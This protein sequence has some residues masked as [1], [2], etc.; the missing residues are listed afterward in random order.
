[1]KRNET[2]RITDE[3]IAR[4]R[5]VDLVSF[6]NRYEPAGELKRIG[7][8]WTLKSHDSMRISADGRWNWFSQGMGGGDAISYL[9]AVHHMRFVEA[10][11]TLAGGDYPKTAAKPQPRATPDREPFRLPERAENNRRVFAYLSARGIDAEIIN[12]CM[13]AG[14]LYEESGHHNAVF[15]GQDEND[16]PRYAFLRGTMTGSHFRQE[17]KGSDK[18]FGFCLRGTGHTLYVCEAAIDALSVATLRKLGGRDWRKDN[19]LS[20]GGVTAAQDKLPP[21][22]E[23]QLRSSSFKQVI[24][25]LDHDPAGQAASRNIFRLMREQWPD[26]SLKICEPQAKDFNEQLCIKR[27]GNEQKPPSR[28]TREYALPR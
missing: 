17:Q 9:Q 3:Q 13:K 18:S 20:L 25:C 4:A 24:L 7:Q 21:A 26:I 14:S 6:L 15:V 16:M 27:N 28:G 12:H 22:L 1:M 5:E 19:Y 2:N 11:Q 10:V 8:S 23:R